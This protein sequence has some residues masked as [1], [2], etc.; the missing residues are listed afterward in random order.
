MLSQHVVIQH[1][2]AGSGPGDGWAV[3][4]LL[5]SGEHARCAEQCLCAC[6]LLVCPLGWSI[7]LFQVTSDEFWKGHCVMC[8]G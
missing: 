6:S 1:A 2:S 4:L 7:S 5:Q 8:P 3:P